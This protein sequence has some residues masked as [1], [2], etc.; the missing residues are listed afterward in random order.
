VGKRGPTTWRPANGFCGSQCFYDIGIDAVD[1]TNANNIQIGGA[2]RENV[3]YPYQ[4]IR[5]TARH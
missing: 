5:P 4:E 3:L 1:P 2:A